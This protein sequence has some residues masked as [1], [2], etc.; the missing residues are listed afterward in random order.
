M[1]TVQI[2]IDSVDRTSVIVFATAS[3]ESAVNGTVGTCKFR[4]RDEDR[5]LSFTVGDAIELLVDGDPVWTGFLQSWSR[6]YAFP[7]INV[8]EAGLTRWIDIE[9]VDLNILFQKRIV[10]TVADPD[11]VFGKL[12][13]PGTADS[14]A[15]ADLVADYLD[16]SGDGLDV[17]T[18]VETVAD[19]NVDQDARAWSG[20]YTWAQAMASIAMLP[21]GVFFI[22]PARFLVYTD[23]NTANA[24]FAMSDQPTG[25]DAGYREM[26]IVMDG[27]SLANDVFAWGM[28][29]GSS[30]PVFV[31]DQDATSLAAHGRW[32]AGVVRAG[33]YKQA[34]IN[35]VAESI[36][37]GSP[38]S[39]RGAKDDRVAVKVVTYVPGFLPAQKVDFTSAVFDFNDVIPIR[40][41]R[42]TFDTPDTPKY[43]L[44][45]SHAI[46]EPWG[47]WD[48]FL[49]DF[50][51]I[52]FPPFPPPP[53][54]PPSAGP[55][56]IFER[57]ETG[58]WGTPTRGTPDWV[59]VEDSVTG[60]GTPVNSI[61][62]G[63]G[64]GRNQQSLPKVTVPVN[65]RATTDLVLDV[66]EVADIDEF[67]FEFDL[68]V[69]ALNGGT[70]GSTSLHLLQADLGAGSGLIRIDLQLDQFVA[71][72]PQIRWNVRDS[73]GGSGTPVS[74]TL[75]ATGGIDEHVTINRSVTRGTTRI[76]IGN[77]IDETVVAAP[78]PAGTPFLRFFNRTTR[79]TATDPAVTLVS[80]FSVDN[81]YTYP[82]GPGIAGDISASL[83]GFGCQALARIDST[84]YQGTYDYVPGSTYVWR[85]G[86]LQRKGVD[87]TESS[88]SVVFATPVAATE[89]VFMCYQMTGVLG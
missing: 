89:F 22:D 38:S 14:T 31:R 81:I 54:P 80:D 30:E 8:V 86:I 64:W 11:D 47:F 17:S 56:D 34:T 72:P 37:D 19:I 3:F 51:R 35:R 77:L 39:Q 79:S 83:F 62:V 2:K 50:P 57:V 73:L 24:P 29:Y 59:T 21:A 28:G 1:A 61:L 7:A 52:I 71:L 26:S 13:G 69:T 70:P 36:V 88:P 44:D 58:Q 46:D 10:H 15:I 60:T 48:Q 25:D 45:L 84:E 67:I 63:G 42:V 65:N 5:T 82:Q 66:A 43:E 12:Y 78:G 55:I 20:G 32:Q 18:K 76:T 74:G 16:L 49:F 68:V 87:Y 75:A 23:V 53:P 40:R 9:G 41:M 4:V 33:I 85:S 6:V 27:T